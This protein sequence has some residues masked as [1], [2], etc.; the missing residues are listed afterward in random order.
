[1]RRAASLVALLLAAC[2]S[3][4]SAPP[5]SPPAPFVHVIEAT[6]RPSRGG[7]AI[8]SFAAHNAGAAPDTLERADCR[9]AE[10]T[11]VAGDVTIAP[12][13]TAAFTADGPH[14]TFTGFDGEIGDV[15]KVTLTFANAGEQ[16]VDADVT[17][18]QKT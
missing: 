4:P 11:E 18:R 16:V 9:C 5:T 1:M 15:V 13:Q 8:L 14:V 2:S 6:V 17:R 3:E 10:D 12:E 7:D